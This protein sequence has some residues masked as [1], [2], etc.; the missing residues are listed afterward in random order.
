MVPGVA[1]A[2]AAVAVL[3]VAT[4]RAPDPGAA[5]GAAPNV[6]RIGSRAG[7]VTAPGTEY[8]AFGIIPASAAGT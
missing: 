8:V 4:W 3:I 1:T 5:V 6:A 2:L 7:L